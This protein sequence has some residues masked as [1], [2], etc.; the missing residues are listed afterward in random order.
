MEHRVLTGF[1]E[2]FQMAEHAVPRK[3]VVQDR[4]L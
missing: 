2:A 3:A 4:I 1:S